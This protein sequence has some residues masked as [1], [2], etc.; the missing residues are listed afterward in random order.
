LIIMA[1]MQD[2]QYCAYSFGGN[3]V[4]Q[5]ERAA[6]YMVDYG[7]LS[8][9]VATQVDRF[10]TN[11]GEI[12]QFSAIEQGRGA[13]NRY[14]TTELC[15]LAL[16]KA[17]MIESSEYNETLD[18][19]NPPQIF[20]DWKGEATW[21]KWLGTPARKGGPTAD[22]F[23]NILE[24]NAWYMAQNNIR[25]TAEREAIKTDYLAKAEQSV[26]DGRLSS[27]F[28]E[29][30]ME[31]AGDATLLIADPLN[32]ET[33]ARAYDKV[34]IATIRY[35]GDRHLNWHELT[36]LVG[37]FKYKLP[38]EVGTEMITQE[39]E[40]GTVT[41]ANMSMYVFMQRAMTRVLDSAGV[42]AYEMSDLYVGPHEAKNA[43]RLNALVEQR[44]GKDGLGE[45]DAQFRQKRRFWLPR[46]LFT[47]DFAVMLAGLD[48]LKAQEPDMS[49]GELIA[50][51][52]PS[53]M[54]EEEAQ[55]L[56]EALGLFSGRGILSTIRMI[57][58]SAKE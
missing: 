43:K 57:R 45:L 36:H 49:Y 6:D 5:N 24:W 13:R 29:R 54:N 21:G 19:A 35:V 33:A 26:R 50:R 44:T 51:D 55:T 58:N 34:N 42:T 23:M 20:Q 40:P 3:I 37:G 27:R 47:R 8:G 38:N 2:W 1:E 32:T 52:L 56:E 4:L 41:E 14:L 7:R 18:A 15:R 12:V 39:L 22:Q 9:A 30:A 25:H 10:A 31:T 17:A 11:V 48:I 28:L 46:T 16:R 53:A